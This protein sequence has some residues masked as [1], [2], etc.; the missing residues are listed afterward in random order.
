MDPL[1]QRVA[2]R[3]FSLSFAITILTS[4]SCFFISG[5]AIGDVI[6]R[7]PSNCSSIPMSSL[8]PYPRDR[9]LS[10]FF[11]RPVALVI[12]VRNLEV[13]KHVPGD[14]T[15]ARSSELITGYPIFRLWR[16]FEKEEF[17]EA[18]K[19]ARE[20]LRSHTLTKGIAGAFWRSVAGI[21]TYRAGDFLEA[22]EHFL[23]SG[24]EYSGSGL[25]ANAN[26]SLFFCAGGG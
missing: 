3:Q 18:S 4:T 21:C 23:Q 15:L 19:V 10:E 22:A 17:A 7:I 9:K 14:E 25:I 8:S 6:G 12:R 13:P 20:I 24:A 11:V 5:A 26:V 1:R 16:L 2:N